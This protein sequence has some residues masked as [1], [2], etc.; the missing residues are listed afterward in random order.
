MTQPQRTIA[1]VVETTGVGLHTGETVRVRFLPA[2]IDTGIVF[3]R[4][5]LP[6][7]PRIPARAEH[8]IAQ[9][10]RTAIQCGDAEVHTVEH[11]ISAAVGIGIDNLDIELAGAEAP[12]FDGSA[13]EYVK[14]LRSAGLADQDARRREVVV[15]QPVKVEGRNGSEL[16]ALPS[17]RGLQITYT[18][19]Y[20]VKPLRNVR[21]E[22]DVTEE[23][24]ADEIAPA[25]TFCLREE[26]ELLRA[27][28]MGAGATLDNT[29]VFDDDGPVG[30]ASLRFPDEA[31]RHK[32]LDLVGDL[33]L[34]GSR[35]RAH[36]VAVK[37]G[38]ELNLALVQ[39]LLRTAGAAGTPP[40]SARSS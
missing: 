25:R 3:V 10:R 14:L 40:R 28:G 15:T 37:S 32:V 13:V 17:A 24:Y 4:T 31:A 34:L 6:G 30:G 7:R 18:L 35:L 1:R 5:D 38:H 11:L 19:D 29:L 12:G 36:V 22:L 20:P 8:R 21:V 33:A 23:R 9:P 16:T 2:A 26:A 39:E 27:F